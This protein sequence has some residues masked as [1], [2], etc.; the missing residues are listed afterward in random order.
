[1]RRLRPAVAVVVIAVS[2]C[3]AD[4]GGEGTRPK[5]ALTPRYPTETTAVTTPPSGDGPAPAGAG[6]GAPST[7]V[8][9]APGGGAAAAAASAPTTASFGDPTGDLTVSVDRPPRYADLAGATLT[10]SASG[11]ELRVRLGDNAPA[12]GAEGRTLNV[13]SFYDVTG[14]GGVDYEIWLNLGEGGWGGAYFDNTRR[15]GNRF[16]QQAGVTVEVAGNEV[17]GRFPLAHLASAET[18]RWSLASEW[19]RYEVI[20]TTAAARDDAPDNDVPARFPAP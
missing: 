5:V 12:T 1:M 20:G 16:G 14:D 3:S 4:G 6:G 9:G 10:R 19:G 18:F 7:A 2:A 17:V 13:A 11:F 15:G 8:A